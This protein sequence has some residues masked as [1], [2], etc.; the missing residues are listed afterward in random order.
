MSVLSRIQL[1]LSIARFDEDNTKY[2]SI[3]DL[4]VNLLAYLRGKGDL[5]PIKPTVWRVFGSHVGVGSQFV[6]DFT[7]KPADY[8]TGNMNAS[9]LP[10]VLTLSILDKDELGE[11]PDRLTLKRHVLKELSD[12]KTFMIMLHELTH[13]YDMQ[14]IPGKIFDRDV[15]RAEH[16]KPTE[17]Y[18]DSPTEF[19]TL[20][21]EKESSLRQLLL[22]FKRAATDTTKTEVIEKAKHI[23]GKNFYEWLNNI[24]K[25]WVKGYHIK[26]LLSPKRQKHLLKRLVPLYIKTRELILDSKKV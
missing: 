21:V 3:H 6:I 4:Y 15:E 11:H 7:I 16:L 5:Y 20:S 19:N 9:K 1:Y 8:F 14:R 22:E 24:E 2:E 26:H 10:H 23:L 17:H 25:P 13:Y 12:K 18:S